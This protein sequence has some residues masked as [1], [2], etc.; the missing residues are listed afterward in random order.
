[1]PASRPATR[2]APDVAPTASAS[3]ANWATRATSLDDSRALR[4]RCTSAP[5]WP[6]RGETQVVGGKLGRAV[7]VRREPG[8]EA[9]QEGGACRES[10]R[11]PIEPSQHARPEN[12]HRPASGLRPTRSGG[13]R[14]AAP[15]STS[16]SR[17]A[18]STRAHTACPSRW[19]TLACAIDSCRES[20][21]GDVQVGGDLRGVRHER[22]GSGCHDAACS[23]STSAPG[24][25]MRLPRRSTLS[26]TR[27]HVRRSTTRSPASTSVVG[28]SAMSG[29]TSITSRSPDATLQARA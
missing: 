4:S 3:S 5:K 25:V 6:L 15:A 28:P 22:S 10:R 19:M 7:R 8:A 23:R 12:R 27:K 21:G 13:R 26:R 29:A 14:R 1:M 9:G 16:Q 24:D 20:R 17:H 2:S 18:C 11:K